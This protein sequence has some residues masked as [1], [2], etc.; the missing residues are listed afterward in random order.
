MATL[1]GTNAPNGY[2][3]HA[4]LGYMQNYNLTVEHDFGKGDVIEI[5]FVSGL[6]DAREI[7]IDKTPR[8]DVHMTN[9]G[10]PH[11]LIGQTDSGP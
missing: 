2:H 10:V 4:P 11:L 8:A 3:V 9:F 7:L 6:T 1:A 5:G